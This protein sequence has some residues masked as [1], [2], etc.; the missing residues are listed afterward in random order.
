MAEENP[1]LYT[2]SHKVTLFDVAGDL[3]EGEEKSKPTSLLGQI[4]FI[5][6]Y[7]AV[8][9]MLVVE[10]TCVDTNGFLDKLPIRSGMSVE[11]SIN[12]ASRGE[13]EGT[14][15]F[16]F[17]QDKNNELIIVN[18]SNNIKQNKREL[19]T[20]TCVT[21]TS[22]SN[23]TTRVI[24]RYDN[25]LSDSVKSILTDVLKVAV[26]R[27]MV[28]PTDNSYS[29][30]GNFVRPMNLI[31]KLASKSLKS[32]GKED[33]SSGFVGFFFH[34]SELR[35]YIF[36]SI[37]TCLEKE[38][39]FPKYKQMA[40][41]DT[42]NA[43]PF[44][45]SNTPRFKENHDLIKKLRMGQYKASNI[46]YNIMTRTVDFHEYKSDTTGDVAST[47]DEAP[48]RRLLSVL[49]LG[50]TAAE[51]KELKK[52]SEAVTWRQSHAAARYQ[53]LYSQ[54][55]DVTIPMNLKLEVGMI[56]MFDF[57]DINTGGES[58]G[59]TPNSGKY[60]IVKLSHEFGNPQGDFTGLT[61]VRQSY[62][63][64]EE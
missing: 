34:E 59:K 10:I 54:L 16:S 25:K 31:N 5:K 53:S 61:L 21:K 4:L 17:T 7:E 1:G 58:G 3:E 47:V 11:L 36:E 38:T 44:T 45:F 39:E 43:D 41:K 30:C 22:L 55:V 19:F 32:E 27:L 63:P 50:S 51:G 62:T 40:F 35:G 60:L 9:N 6:Y 14:E 24:K 33:P 26:D 13:E 57:P 12:H 46:V 64:Y 8:G 52:L 15:P 28:E 42:M 48:S 49:D 37:K 23:H 18:I 56:L 29:F 20:L 2:R